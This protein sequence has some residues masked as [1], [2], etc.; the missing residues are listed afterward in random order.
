[1]S[2]AQRHKCCR[3]PRVEL[4]AARA[5]RDFRTEIAV[6]VN[7]EYGIGFYS[8]SPIAY[9]WF[10]IRARSA[11]RADGKPSAQHRNAATMEGAI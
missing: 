5:N 6:G 4:R 11:I 2:Y 10:F 7:G 8:R 3:M 1:M 9:G